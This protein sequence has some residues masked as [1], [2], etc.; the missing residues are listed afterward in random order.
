[1]VYHTFMW[2]LHKNI[3]H[4]IC[5]YKSIKKTSLSC[6]NVGI[7]IYVWATYVY[8]TIHWCI[9]WDTEQRCKSKHDTNCSTDDYCWSDSFLSSRISV[10]V[11]IQQKLQLYTGVFVDIDI[12]L[13]IFYRTS[14]FYL[15]E[16]PIYISKNHLSRDGFLYIKRI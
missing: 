4:N 8:I 1:M 10:I 3:Y 5:C 13:Q 11:E 16:F 12:I 15:F 9:F 7:D 14:I 6:G 2:S